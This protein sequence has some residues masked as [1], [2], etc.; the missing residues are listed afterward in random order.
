MSSRVQVGDGVQLRGQSRVMTVFA[1]NEEERAKDLS[2]P[3]MCHAAWHTTE[4]EPRQGI[5]LERCLNV[6]EQAAAL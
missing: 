1:T 4:G 2:M 3:R 5:F 6:V